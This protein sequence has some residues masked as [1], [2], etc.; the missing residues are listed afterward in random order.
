ML[1][2]HA[3]LCDLN[4]KK[5]RKNFT[6]PTP[7]NKATRMGTAFVWACRKF[8]FWWPRFTLVMAEENKK[9]RDVTRLDQR[10]G[11]FVALVVG[12]N[13]KGHRSME[14]C[15]TVRGTRVMLLLWGGQ[16]CFN[17]SLSL[18]LSLNGRARCIK[19]AYILRQLLGNLWKIYMI[20]DIV[21]IHWFVLV[22][23][24]LEIDRVTES[25]VHLNF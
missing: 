23:S 24:M 19:N 2:R 14:N 3:L 20:V 1:T 4:A 5:P 18:S 8:L 25:C 16:F 11:D 17:F 6:F 22:W 21:I 12:G 9:S 7:R 15:T 10:H 13:K